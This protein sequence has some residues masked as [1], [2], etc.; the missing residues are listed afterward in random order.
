MNIS[1]DIPI[2][3]VTYINPLI[4]ERRKKHCTCK[5]RTFTIDAANREV[6]CDTCGS[7]IDPFEV[8]CDIAFRNKKF[9]DYLEQR[10]EYVRELNKWFIHN[11]IPI[12]IKRL[13]EDYKFH[14]SM[15]ATPNCPHCGKNFDFTD[16]KCFSNPKFKRS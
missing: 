4:Q 9:D 13:V 5:D 16:I 10:T 1:N 12:A 6:I 11:K 8:L 2:P 7:I 15:G 14:A 3:K